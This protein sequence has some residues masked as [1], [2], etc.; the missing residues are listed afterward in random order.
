MAVTDFWP[1]VKERNIKQAEK[2]YPYTSVRSGCGYDISGHTH[3]HNPNI[4]HILWHI[5]VSEEHFLKYVIHGC[6]TREILI[7][8]LY[9]RL[10]LE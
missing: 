1:T 10:D 2:S 3:V 6:E 5:E 9:L 8:T 4:K 7:L